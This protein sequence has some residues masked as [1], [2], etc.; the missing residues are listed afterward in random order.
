MRAMTSSKAGQER[1][2]WW[3]DISDKG[4]RMTS[5]ENSSAP[6]LTWRRAELW[7]QR[8]LTHHPQHSHERGLCSLP[9]PGPKRPKEDSQ[10]A[11]IQSEFEPRMLG[12]KAHV[13]NHWLGWE[14]QQEC[15]LQLRGTISYK[16]GLDFVM[17]FSKTAHFKWQRC[18]VPLWPN[19]KTSSPLRRSLTTGNR[20]LGV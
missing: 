7:V 2:E 11:Q 17:W 10:L 19:E 12:F 20:G 3:G 14:Y 13:F 6:V 5:G 15:W 18:P 9:C 8:M 4:G 16:H 1:R